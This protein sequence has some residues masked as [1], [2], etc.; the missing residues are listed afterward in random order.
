MFDDSKYGREA[1]KWV[2]GVV[3]ACILVY[4]GIRHLGTIAGAVGW[5]TNLFKP[6]LT[7]AVL[8]LI[9][10]VPM[11]MIE[12]RV[13]KKLQRGKRPLAILLTLILGGGNICRRRVSCYSGAAERGEPDRTNRK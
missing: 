8:A 7:G 6:L 4:L 1:A 13:L 11:G 5:L 10:N 9:L 2:I 3:S 12:D